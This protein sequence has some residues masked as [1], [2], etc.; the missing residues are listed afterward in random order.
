MSDLLRESGDDTAEYRLKMFKQLMSE[1]CAYQIVLK[2]E[3][4]MTEEECTSKIQGYAHIE[5]SIIE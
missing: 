4:L 2:N 3:G 5:H 1:A